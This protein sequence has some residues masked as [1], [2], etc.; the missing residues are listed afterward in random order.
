[1]VFLSFPSRLAPEIKFQAETAAFAF[2]A[3]GARPAAD[4]AAIV[5]ELHAR[6]EGRVG[7]QAGVV[8]VWTRMQAPL[9]HLLSLTQAPDVSCED[10]LPV[11]RS[12][13]PIITLENS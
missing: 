10:A 5:V 4:A 1:V 3:D 9:R 2:D 7:L 13:T 6:A 11:P 8:F 12:K